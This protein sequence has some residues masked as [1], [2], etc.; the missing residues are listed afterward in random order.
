MSRLRG[1]TYLSTY[2]FQAVFQAIL[3]AVHVFLVLLFPPRLVHVVLRLFFVVAL[4][5]L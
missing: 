5:K 4:S 2:V 1:M 3:F